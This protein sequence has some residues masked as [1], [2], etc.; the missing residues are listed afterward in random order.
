MKT[1]DDPGWADI[2]GAIASRTIPV[3]PCALWNL[4]RPGLGKSFGLNFSMDDVGEASYAAVPHLVQIHE[5]LGV[6]DDNVYSIV[7]MIDEARRDGSNPELPRDLASL[8]T[9]LFRGW[10]L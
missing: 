8:I 7:V 3:L 1:F 6:P 9:P 4:A 2:K 10:P 5:A